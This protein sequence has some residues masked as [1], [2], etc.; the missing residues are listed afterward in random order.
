MH[1]CLNL[2][3]HY[4]MAR[5]STHDVADIVCRVVTTLNDLVSTASTVNQTS[6]TATARANDVQRTPE[7]EISVSFRLPRNEQQGQGDRTLLPRWRNG[8]FAPYN[9]SKGKKLAVCDVTGRQ[10]TSMKHFKFTCQ[11]HWKVGSYFM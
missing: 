10:A 8:R 2:N 1:D 9:K 3:D 5:R 7:E 4:K 6:Q 11:P